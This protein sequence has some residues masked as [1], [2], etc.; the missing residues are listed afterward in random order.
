MCCIAAAR[1]A[2]LDR[3]HQPIAAGRCESIHDR[4]LHE[5]QWGAVVQSPDGGVPETIYH[6]EDEFLP[7]VGFRCSHLGVAGFLYF[8]YFWRE[9]QILIPDWTYFC[10]VAPGQ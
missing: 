10:K 8:L 1:Q 5:L 2:D 3:I 7:L 9:N 4:G 6:R